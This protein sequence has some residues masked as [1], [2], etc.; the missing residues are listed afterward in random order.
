M[1]FRKSLIRWKTKENGRGI[2]HADINVSM[3]EFNEHNL[4]VGDYVKILFNEDK[5]PKLYFN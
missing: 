3:K 1:S 2:S 4:K 5:F